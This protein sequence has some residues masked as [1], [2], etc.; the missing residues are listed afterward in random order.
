MISN[1]QLIFKKKLLYQSQNRGCKETDLII[2][3]FTKKHID[4][5]NNEDLQELQTILKINDTDFYDWY[6]KKKPLPK[7]YDSPLM[8]K[9]LSFI[10]N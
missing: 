1:S 9:L 3:S 7:N 2:G 10:P 4:T 8:H 6:T 5:M